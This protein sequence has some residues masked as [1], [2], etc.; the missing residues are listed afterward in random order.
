MHFYTIQNTSCF[1]Q[2][3]SAFGL[4]PGSSPS[5]WCTLPVAGA[6]KQLRTN[7]P[8]AAIATPTG[9]RVLVPVWVWGE[10]TCWLSSV[11]YVTSQ[12]HTQLETVIHVIPMV[13]ESPIYIA[14][15]STFFRIPKLECWKSNVWRHQGESQKD[16]DSSQRN[17]L[18]MW[19]MLF[20]DATIEKMKVI[21]PCSIPKLYSLTY[22]DDGKSFIHME[23][24]DKNVKL[25]YF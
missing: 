13:G 11:S 2:L 12:G 19:D 20:Q 16:T 7:V 17:D 5:V 8:V 22:P 9:G 18:T 25:S 23:S 6:G 15:M 3:F 24:N 1:Q 4:L 14:K 10:F 21:C